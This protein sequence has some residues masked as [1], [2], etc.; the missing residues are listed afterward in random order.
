MDS[1]ITQRTLTFAQGLAGQF[2]FQWAVYDAS[3][4]SINTLPASPTGNDLG[5]GLY[6]FNFTVL[7]ASTATL[8]VY[9]SSRS[10]SAPEQV[11]SVL[12]ILV[13]P[14]VFQ[15][16]ATT[17]LYSNYSTVA[18][19]QPAFIDLQLRD[20]WGNPQTSSVPSIVITLTYTPSTVN[21]ASASATALPS[22]ITD[23]GD[24]TYGVVYTA[25]A[26]LSSYNLYI[27]VNNLN[28][29]GSPFA[30]TALDP[31]HIPASIQ[32]AFLVLSA[33][34]GAIVLVLMMAV[35]A[36]GNSA[37][38]KT[39][40]PLFLEL[41]GVGLLMCI[42]SV[43]VYGYPS[44]TTCRLF[45]FLLTTGYM[46]ALSAL[47]AKLYR[48]YAVYK[49]GSASAGWLTD[50]TMLAPV[51]VLLV[52]ETILNLVWLIADPLTLR[53]FNAGT[54]LP[55]QQ[56]DGPYATAFIASSLGFNL[57][58]LCVTVWL[59]FRVRNVVD[60]TNETKLMAAALYNLLLILIIAVS[61]TWTA[62]NTQSS[63]EDFLIP[64]AAIL[65]C[66]AVTAFTVLAP[67]IY[68]AKYPPPTDAGK[69]IG[70]SRRGGD[71][72]G[73]KRRSFEAVGMTAEERAAKRELRR[74][75]QLE[76][77]RWRDDD[78]RTAA[79]RQA[80]EGSVEL[81][82][83]RQADVPLT[84]ASPQQMEE[85][86]ELYPAGDLTSTG[87]SGD[88]VPPAF[89]AARRNS[90]S[91][92]TAQRPA[93]ITT[94]NQGGV[95]ASPPP[96][97]GDSRSLTRGG[98]TTASLRAHSR[99]RRSMGGSGRVSGGMVVNSPAMGGSRASPSGGSPPSPQLSAKS[100]GK[101]GGGGGGSGKGSGRVSRGSG[102]GVTPSASHD[103]LYELSEK[104]HVVQ[105]D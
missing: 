96:V 105:G 48:L 92:R 88:A 72:E 94:M 71:P 2:S 6:S 101:R 79:A 68:F 1:P 85:G 9:F 70:T 29:Q 37:A 93:P 51:V 64:A 26:E 42:A 13:Q 28:I 8:T 97:R 18:K 89:N 98:G 86:A 22:T 32:V 91:A 30:V 12:H 40:S 104:L 17:L 62:T 20:S 65:W 47:F 35:A 99:D 4:A 31:L 46:F 27:R 23:N 33:V 7:Q 66:A 78:P 52:M 5:Q 45:P 95:S 87:G 43:P 103:E 19:G 80:M 44:P 58:V 54:V 69:T 102:F 36:K 38:V 25:P 67:R 53:T 81:E 63:H 60:G 84:S 14:D 39:A 74:S 16:H 90:L 41:V 57:L 3:G 10:Q 55:Y 100:A 77:G 75:Q 59:A 34:L 11:N 83:M 76:G 21:N 15:P 61:L 56:C 24:G 73:R 50:A 49:S 82:P